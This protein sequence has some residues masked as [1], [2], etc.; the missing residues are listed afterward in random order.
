[1]Y[2]NSNIRGLTE[3]QTLSYILRSIS[4][5]KNEE[6]IAERFD[7]DILLV[8]TWIGALKQTHYV[9]TNHFNKLVITSY[10]ENFLQQLDSYR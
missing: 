10:G 5:G 2:K 8:K 6:Q 1:M 4:D 7:R 3:S 9:T